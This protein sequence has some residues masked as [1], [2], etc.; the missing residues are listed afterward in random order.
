M[1]KSLMIAGS[2][3]ASV[4][5]FGISSANARD[6]I[7]WSVSVGV[8]LFAPP[9]VYAPPV[10]RVY[11]QPPVVEYREP[12]YYGYREQEW[13]RREWREHEWRRHERREHEW[14]DRREYEQFHRN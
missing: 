4:L 10:Q 6:H 3:I 7:D 2:V 1:K 12:V 9:V 8:P 14:H 5:A 13:R 11:V